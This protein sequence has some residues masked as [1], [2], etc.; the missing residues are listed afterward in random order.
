MGLSHC[1]GSVGSPGIV[2]RILCHVIAL[3]T[4]I[5]SD[6]GE[7]PE[8]VSKLVK[9]KGSGWLHTHREEVMGHL[10]RESGWLLGLDRG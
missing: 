1:K 5:G 4:V 8:G 7:D 2:T 10:L 3:P 6:T 9:A